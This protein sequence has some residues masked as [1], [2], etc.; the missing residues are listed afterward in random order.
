M[1]KIILSGLSLVLLVGCTAQDKA[2]DIGKELDAVKKN[3]TVT[4]ETTNKFIDD[5]KNTIQD[6]TQMVQ[7]GIETTRNTIDNVKTGVNDTSNALQNGVQSLG[8]SV[9]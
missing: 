5:T 7:S 2:P 9:R 8:N 6:T 1:Q 4:V 3:V